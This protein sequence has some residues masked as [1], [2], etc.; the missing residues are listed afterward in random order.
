MR[1]P[2]RAKFFV[3]ATLVAVVPLA[4]VGENLV[5]ITRDELKSAAN[6]QLTE[7]AA[8]VSG[9]IDAAYAG[10]WMTPLMLVRFTIRCRFAS[11]YLILCLLQAL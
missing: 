4:L 9:E 8:Q 2:L 1:F 3:L 11:K 6:E 5:R 7:V 10:R